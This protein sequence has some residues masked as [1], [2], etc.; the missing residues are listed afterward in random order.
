MKVLSGFYYV[1]EDDSQQIFQT[2]ARGIFRKKGQTPLVGDEVAFQ[3]ENEREGLVMAIEGRKNVLYRPPV[4]NVDLA[5]IVVSVEDPKIPQKLIDRLLVSVES[6]K[7]QPLIY[8]TKLDILPASRKL[9]FQSLREMYCEIGYS[10]LDNLALKENLDQLKPYFQGKTVVTLGQSGVGKTTFLNNLL[11]G[12]NKETGEISKALG[13]GRHTTRHV[14]LHKVFSGLLAD[15]PGFSSISFDH[16]E[17]ED[18]SEYFPEMKS[19]KADC[20]FRECS[21]THEPGC[22]I[23]EALEL[24]QITKSRYESYLDFY[25]E[26]MNRKPNYSKNIRRK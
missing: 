23:K 10:C 9:E 8:F 17:G 14:E 20:K 13:R 25:Q 19:R 3:A 1:E 2:R 22:A 12:L 7:I 21:H 4:S 6:H 11:P 16:I 26:I 5:I 15:T 24:G 18:L